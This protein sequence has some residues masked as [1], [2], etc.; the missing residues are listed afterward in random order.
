MRVVIA[1]VFEKKKHDRYDRL[2]CNN[3]YIFV[4]NVKVKAY[5]VSTY[6]H[7]LYASACVFILIFLIN[8]GNEG[9]IYCIILYIRRTTKE[10]LKPVCT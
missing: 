6:I 10:W 9:I 7:I 1:A 3:K 5:I 2:Q 8:G 4:R